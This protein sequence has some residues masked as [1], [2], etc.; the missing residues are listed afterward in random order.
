MDGSETELVTISFGKLLEYYMQYP[1]ATISVEA[2]RIDEGR[3]KPER[4]Y[5]L[6]EQ[7]KKTDDREWPKAFYLLQKRS[8]DDEETPQIQ[9]Q[10]IQAFF[11]EIRPGPSIFGYGIIYRDLIHYWG[12]EFKWDS[13]PEIKPLD[14]LTDV[15][16]LFRA[17]LSAEVLEVNFQLLYHEFLPPS[18]RAPSE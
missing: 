15:K 4:A 14:M 17:S 11:T 1:P 13:E 9:L 2:S 10:R 12:V 6:Q 7:L 18:P 5:Q 3:L 16:K 8:P